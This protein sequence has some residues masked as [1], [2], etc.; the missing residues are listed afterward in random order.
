[1]PARG[2]LCEPGRA[3]GRGEPTVELLASLGKPPL[4]E[5][6]VGI[7]LGY[8]TAC[9][10]IPDDARP[11]WKTVLCFPKAPQSSRYGIMMQ[12]KG[13][14]WTVTLAGRFGD[15]P[16]G[17]PNGFMDFARGLRTRTIADAI[18]PAKRVGLVS[19]SARGPA[20][21]AIFPASAAFRRG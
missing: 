2:W 9:F 3:S 14:C 16:P 17:D 10:A 15:K 5:T 21:A 19:G 1:M 7:D 20:C 18:G 11:D 4:Q 6:C 13:N 8:S 12:V